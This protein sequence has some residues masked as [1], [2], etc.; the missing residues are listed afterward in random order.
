MRSKQGNIYSNKVKSSMHNFFVEY[1]KIIYVLALISLLSI[2][3]ACLTVFK[4]SSKLELANMTNEALIKF[5]KNDTS[6]WSL[7]FKLFFD[8]LII[9]AIAIFLN[10]KPFCMIFNIVALIMYCYSWA[11]NITIFILLYGMFGL[12]CSILIFIPYFVALLVVYILISTISIK[13]CILK[14]KYGNMCN[15]DVDICRFYFV[16]ISISAILLIIECNLL[17]IIHSTI[18][19]N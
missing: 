2:L 16:L 13:R 5:I 7:F 10:I 6:K 8:Y 12:L 4:Y 17:Q 3:T 19:V 11:F 1:R 14:K 9:C 15:F 18:I